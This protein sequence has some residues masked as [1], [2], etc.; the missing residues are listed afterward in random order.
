MNDRSE[1]MGEEKCYSQSPISTRF[2]VVSAVWKESW[3]VLSHQKFLTDSLLCFPAFSK[4][5]E[6]SNQLNYYLK[7]N[8]RNKIWDILESSFNN[9]RFFNEAHFLIWHF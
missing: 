8:M 6:I 5:F 2:K 7:V 4:M 9:Y 3:K 1:K